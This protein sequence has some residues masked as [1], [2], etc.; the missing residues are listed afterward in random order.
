MR[1]RTEILSDLIHFKKNPMDLQAEIAQYPWD[2]EAPLIVLTKDNFINIIQ[3]AIND[4]LTLD[5]IEDWANVIECRDDIEMEN[6][7]IQE[8]IFELA[9]PVLNGEL[10][11]ERLIEIVKELS[12]N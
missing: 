6:E 3:K 9:N 5:E 12:C 4:N 2:S 7:K 1:N 8:Y 11:K 10:T